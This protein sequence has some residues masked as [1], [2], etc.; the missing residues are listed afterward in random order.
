MDNA[1]NEKLEALK[2]LDEF[3]EKLIPG[4]GTLCGE[5]R[6]NRQPDTEV[7]L[8]QCMDGL[9]WAVEVYN[10]TSDLLEEKMHLDKQEL[11]ARLTDLGKA[12]RDKEEDKIAEL[13]EGAVVPFLEGMKAAAAA[14]REEG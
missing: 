13:L 14:C 12:V 9:N 1:R 3:L 5:L 2:A 11:N 10:R 4:M 8:N 6:G 7:Y